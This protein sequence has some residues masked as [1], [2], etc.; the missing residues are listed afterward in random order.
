M[1]APRVL[2]QY[3]RILTEAWAFPKPE[4]KFQ[5][6]STDGVY[7]KP[8]TL[9]APQKSLHYIVLAAVWVFIA[10]SGFVKKSAFVSSKQIY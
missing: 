4:E 6:C 8:A 1:F 5:L 7:T 3:S 2:N 10:L 9:S